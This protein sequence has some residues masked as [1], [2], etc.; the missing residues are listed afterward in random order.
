MEQH[1]SSDDD[2]SL[3]GDVDC[4]TLREAADVAASDSRSVD[5][6][7]LPPATV[8][9]V[10]DEEAGDD[11][12][13]S[14]SSLPA[15]V[16]GPLVVHFHNDADREKNEMTKMSS[17]KRLK[18]KKVSVPKWKKQFVYKEHLV[19]KEI[20]T[21]SEL[22]PELA[23]KTPYEL[24][25]L[26]YDDDMRHLIM[27]ESVKYARQKNNQKI[28]A[29]ECDLDVFIGILILSGY[30]SLPREHLYWSRD[31]D[32]D[33][34]YVSSR[35]S[36]NRFEDLKRYLHLADNSCIDGTDKLH[37]IRPFVN[38]CNAKLQQHGVFSQYLSID[39]QMVPY[40]GHHSAKMYIHS[41]PIRF[42]F[43]L[44]VLAS[45]SGY[46][47]YFIVY[48]GKSADTNSDQ[49]KEVGLGHT[50][51]TSL[52]SIV[53]SP[54]CHE[55]F[56]DNYF[57]SYDLLSYL[58]SIKIKATGTA[59]ENRLKQCPLQDT[60]LMKKTPRGTHDS[61][62]DGVVGVVKWHDNQCV[63]VATNYDSVDTV[64][65]VKRWSVAKKAAIEVPQPTVVNS[66]NCHMGG[67][68]MLDAFMANY[69][70]TFRSKKWWWP[71]FLNG[72]NMLVVAA[73]KLHVEVGGK[74]DQLAFRRYIVRSLMHS[75]NTSAPS[76]G[77][78]PRPLDEIRRDGLNHHLSRND[79]Q[80]RCRLC[81][82]NCR[83]KCT[84]CDVP[85]HIHCELD[86]H[87]Q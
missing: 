80:A 19:N 9:A 22:R 58:K 14:P 12:D 81:M 49:V 76:A 41:K 68:D 63:T 13:L 5:V 37:K 36:R 21:L 84:K 86:Y 39:E 32:L 30:H 40:F 83:M 53:S 15:E 28:S 35:M 33:V 24:F 11:D 64:G 46:P 38:H 6:V 69:R 4:C 65:K 27:T 77:P 20:T 78:G 45:D 57:T 16:A 54:E 87:A 50:V 72:V 17:G 1:D 75:V 66:Y 85:L 62:C 44:W 71:L 43:K 8:D 56:F 3:E 67:V 59:R 10:S 29:D 79:K 73:W 18:S 34:S 23:S 31:E 47:Y 51:V 60:K 48:C 74:F 7:I 82:K 42:G 2:D 25:R 52:L 55:V 70:P 26:Y 61:K